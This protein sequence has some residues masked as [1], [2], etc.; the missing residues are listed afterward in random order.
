MDR[1]E[2]TDNEPKQHRTDCQQWSGY[3]KLSCPRELADHAALS[4]T[5]M[6]HAYDGYSHRLTSRRE[7]ADWIGNIPE[8][9]KTIFFGQSLIFSGQ[10]EAAKNG[11]KND[12]CIRKHNLVRQDEMSEILCGVSRAK[13]FRMKLYYLPRK[14][15]QF[16]AFG[17]VR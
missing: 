9:R 10:K 13:P 2:C 12:F 7:G 3:K 1:V 4:G 8:S 15:F 14:Q 17:Q 11:E 6:Q 16:I 5:A